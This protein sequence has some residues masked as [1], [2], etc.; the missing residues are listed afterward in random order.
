VMPRRPKTTDLTATLGELSASHAATKGF[1]TALA[2]VEIAK[3]KG[4]LAHPGSES[5]SDTEMQEHVAQNGI[6]AADHDSE[7]DDTARASAGSGHRNHEMGTYE[8]T[9]PTI[10]CRD[11]SRK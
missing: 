8:R 9:R 5:A 7:T 6:I 10:Q 11:R 2:Y 3:P 1:S 4:R